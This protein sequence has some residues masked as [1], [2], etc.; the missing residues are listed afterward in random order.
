MPTT[1]GLNFFRADPNLASV[2]TIRASEEDAA[3]ALPLLDE[4]GQLAG[5]ELDE[6]ATIADRNPP[7][8]VTHD[9]EG[10]RVD[11]IVYHP[12]YLR[13]QELGFARFGFAAMSHRPGVLGWPGTVPHVVKYALSY[14][15]VQAEFGLFCPISMTDS[16]ARVLRLFGPD[17]LRARYLPGLT[18]T[19]MDTLL[20]SAQLITER[21][22][23]SDVGAS[24]CEARRVDGGWE[25]WGEK[26]FCSN[27]GADVH[28]VL[29]R[30]Q[31]APPGTRGL[32]L[33]LVPKMLP[34]GSRNRYVIRRLKEKLGSRSMPTGEYEFHGAVGY[35]VGE[36][37]RGFRQM[38]E[39][40]NVSRL[41]NGMR[42][43]AL[44]R[45]A[46]LESVVHTRGRAAFGRPLAELP[47][48]RNQLLELTL[49]ADAAAAIVLYAAA[50]L[51]AA[52]AGSEF[53]RAIV[54]I[55]TP[56]IKY[57][58]CRQARVST[59][60][61]MNLRGGNGYIEE[62]PNARL[63]RDAYLG[64]I[65]EGAENVVAL[66]V[67]RAARR[68]GAHDAL[69]GDLDER[70][71]GARSDAVAPL[72]ARLRELLSATRQQFA[73]FLEAWDED[74]EGA[75]PAWCDRLAALVCGV[76]LLEEAD[77]DLVA[78][79]GERKRVVA[80]AFCERRL[81]QPDPLAWRTPTAALLAQLTA[82]A[83]AAGGGRSQ[84]V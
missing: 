68:E 5:G 45:R 28:L 15:F 21:T 76:L 61:A 79:R 19:S 73:R 24:E 11:E 72:A 1:R 13:M 56:L 69:F 43:A 65:W 47:I 31:G 37:E 32:G 75:V 57:A 36:L 82:P 60:L 74:A 30:P 33:F 78:G 14:V 44:I 26:W 39:M 70:L 12:A 67:I 77:A 2:L 38:A 41:S 54:R 9:R 71:A 63:L 34:D 51:D 53:H 42:A 48:V 59:G 10:R 29:A 4:L 23:G 83:H 3:R 16:A 40:I 55:V 8:L 52:D 81:L 27:A 46:W 25:L 64:S 58:V 66:D 62:W 7:V 6:L 17:E 80:T 18:S 35:V 22:G 50:A 84:A 49:D 20:Q